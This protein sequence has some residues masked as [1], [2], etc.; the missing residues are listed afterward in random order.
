MNKKTNYHLQSEEVQQ[1]EAAIHHDRRAEVV[2][3]ATAIRMLHLGYKAGEV[4]EVL[5]V[6]RTSISNWWRRWQ[7]GGVEGLANRPISGRPAKGSDEYWQAAEQTLATDPTELGYPFTVWTVERLRQH[8]LQVTGL[9][10]SGE[11]LRVQLRRRGYV[12]R[13]PRHALTPHQD[14]AARQATLDLLNELKK[15]PLSEPA[16]YSIW[17]RR[18]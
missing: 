15:E 3:R 17:M 9:E 18:A 5:L 12:W 1:M 13:R 10:L 7:A 8:L 2:Q 6:Q 11:R 16:S 14:A 4:A